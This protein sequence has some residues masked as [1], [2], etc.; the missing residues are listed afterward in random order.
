MTRAYRGVMAAI[1]S[2]VDALQALVDEGE[3]TGFVLGVRHGGA[4]HLAAS[5]FSPDAQFVLTSNTKPMAGAL[6]MRLV[7]LGALGLDHPVAEYLPEFA[8]PRVLVRPDGPLDDWVPAERPITVAHLLTM[9]SGFGWVA[10]DGPLLAAM[11]D[12]SVLP[13][14]FP[15]PMDHDEYIGR[16][17]S[18]PLASQPG[19]RWRYHHSSDVLGV[20]LARATGRSLSDLVVEHLTGPLGLH[21]TGFVGEPV[22]LQDVAGAEVPD[23]LF[24]STPRFESLACGLVSTVS[25][26]LVFLAALAQGEPILSR[27]SVEQ[28]RLDHLTPESRAG[29]E[30]F[31]APGC[32]YGFQVEIRPDGS[33]G[34]AGGLGTIGYTNPRTATS[35]AL[36]LAQS[37]ERAGT[38]RAIEAFWPLLR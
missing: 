7:E 13:G 24:T 6:A 29:G 2:A 37:F 3:L 8:E 23:G 17:A 19:T 4:T 22:R 28:I 9:T 15:P 10:E 25:D 16:L 14:P 32:G 12:S 26:Y 30:G 35:A 21:D 36:F 27:T 18:L 1:Q 34:W 33:L 38:A 20:L 5:R 11:A 31:L